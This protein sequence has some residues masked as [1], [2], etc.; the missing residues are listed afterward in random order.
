MA[1]LDLPDVRRDE[2]LQTSRRGGQT[3]SDYYELARSLSQQELLEIAEAALVIA[4]ALDLIVKR[5]GEI[6]TTTVEGFAQV[7]RGGLRHRGPARR[8]SR[9]ER[10]IR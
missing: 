2:D 3:H 7:L 6:H 4:N 5:G 1:R 10:R 8:T 9:A